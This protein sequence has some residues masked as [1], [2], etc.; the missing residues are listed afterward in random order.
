MKTDPHPTPPQPWH[1]E[2]TQQL[3]NGEQLLGW[4]EVD[5][6]SQL[7]FAPGLV[8]VT[9]RRL[10]ARTGTDA[11]WQAWDYRQDLTLLHHD[12]AGVGTLEL[13]DAS[14]RLATWRYTLGQNVAALRLIDTFEEQR[15]SRLSGRPAVKETGTVCPQCKAPLEPDQDECPVCTKE[16]HTP[17]STWTLFRLWRF[18]KPYN[19]QL[20]AGFLLTLASTAATLVPPYLT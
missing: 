1:D 10:L 20:L 5:L 9:D 11:A 15:E 12:H 17:P 18:A 6:D 2:L 7:R 19:K 13:L 8:A 4:L 16:I 3:A 14:R